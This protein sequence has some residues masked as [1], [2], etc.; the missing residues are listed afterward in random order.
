MLQGFAAYCLQFLSSAVSFVLH[1]VSYL[2]RHAEK[3]CRATVPYLSHAPI[4]HAL[5][6]GTQRRIGVLNTPLYK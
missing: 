4:V 5:E 2:K 1:A 6:E 3:A